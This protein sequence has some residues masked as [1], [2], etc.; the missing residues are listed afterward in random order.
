MSKIKEIQE[1]LTKNFWEYAKVRFVIAKQI[2]VFTVTLYFLSYLFTVGGFYLPFLSLDTLAKLT[3]HLYSLLVI[4]TAFFGYSLIEFFI[5]SHF[6]EKKI[7]L[8]I[9]GWIATIFS[10]FALAVHLGFL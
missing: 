4:S 6:P 2:F 1:R 9:A 7:W 5:G 8:F 10:I 3:Y